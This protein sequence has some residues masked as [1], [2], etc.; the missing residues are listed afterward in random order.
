M[1]LIVPTQN[2]E[3]EMN[4]MGA[5]R[6]LDYCLTHKYSA[7]YAMITK[8]RKMYWDHWKAMMCAWKDLSDKECVHK[9]YKKQELARMEREVEKCLHRFETVEWSYLEIL[10][11]NLD[12]AITKVIAGKNNH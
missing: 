1:L 8:M 9:A 11:G 6:C 4:I 2:P 10:R 7:G 3:H 12:R 5:R